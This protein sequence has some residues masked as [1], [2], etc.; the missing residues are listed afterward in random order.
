MEERRVIHASHKCLST[1]YSVPATEVTA[2]NKA[3]E[4]PV[5]REDTFWQMGNNFRALITA[6]RR[7]CVCDLFSPDDG[8]T[9]VILIYWD[10]GANWGHAAV[11]DEDTIEIQ[12][13]RFQN[14]WIP[15][16][17]NISKIV[18]LGR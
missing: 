7:I 2:G 16:Q 5:H 12:G 17:Y 11:S 13:L 9:N 18:L 1:I 15:N 6:T 8:G 4:V 14:T 3:G 10:A